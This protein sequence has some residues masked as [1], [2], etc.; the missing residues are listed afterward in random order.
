[1]GWEVAILEALGK[2]H[3]SPGSMW[4][5]ETPCWR[6]WRNQVPPQERWC[7]YQEAAEPG[8]VPGACLHGGVQPQPDA[9]ECV[10]APVAAS[11]AGKIQII[12]CFL[13][14]WKI[15]SL[16]RKSFGVPSR[17][18]LRAQTSV[19]GLDA[20]HPSCTSL[21]KVHLATHLGTLSHTNELLR[22]PVCVESRRKR[23]RVR[24]LRKACA[25][26]CC[27]CWRLAK[28]VPGGWNE[29]LILR[30]DLQLLA[31]TGRDDTGKEKV[32]VFPEQSVFQIRLVYYREASKTL[33]QSSM[34]KQL[35]LA[36]N[37]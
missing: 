21:N 33:S 10:V 16:V 34:L 7:L 36:Y 2:W 23:R 25:I 6:G 35:K 26:E 5:V 37:E 20:D 14:L 27:H 28:S 9:P 1:M 30:I 22:R 12:W 15:I 3:S 8:T 18:R 32:L 19:T 24:C 29:G 31:A 17:S 11:A 13:T 4:V